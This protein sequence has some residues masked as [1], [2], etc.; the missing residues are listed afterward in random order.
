MSWAAQLSKKWQKKSK[1]AK[2]R[3]KSAAKGCCPCQKSI[4]R[5]KSQADLANTDSIKANAE[6]A[7]IP[8][9]AFSKR[10]SA[11]LMGTTVFLIPTVRV[12]STPRHQDPLH[13]KEQKKN[14]TFRET[15]SRSLPKR[16]LTSH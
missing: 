7:L 14:W 15:L 8:P 10:F 13:Q 12:V 6:S 2:T 9:W 5:Q 4:Q 11:I 3:S 16:F 1:A